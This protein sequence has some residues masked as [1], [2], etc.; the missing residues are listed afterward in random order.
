MIKTDDGYTKISGE[1]NE[2]FAD[3]T[4][5]IRHIRESVTKAI[6]QEVADKAILLSAH[7]AYDEPDVPN[8]VADLDEMMAERGLLK[9]EIV[10]EQS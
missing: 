4:L 7:V 2:I 9:E 5:I 8:L 10:H 1:F 3:L 6:D